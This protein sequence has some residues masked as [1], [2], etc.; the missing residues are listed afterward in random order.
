M[1]KI[2]ISTCVNYHVC[3]SYAANTINHWKQLQDFSFKELWKPRVSPH[4]DMPYEWRLGFAGSFHR[5][6]ITAPP[7]PADGASQEVLFFLGHRVVHSVTRP[8][9]C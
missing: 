1:I 5:R 4:T 6:R 2:V 9:Q 3:P 7:T 8:V